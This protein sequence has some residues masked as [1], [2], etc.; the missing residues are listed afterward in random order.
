MHDV[1]IKNDTGDPIPVTNVGGSSGD[2][3][4]LDGVTASIK[5]TVKNFA[6]DKALAVSLTDSTG[7]QLGTGNGTSAAAQRVT[8]SSDST[9]ILAAITNVVQLNGQAIAMGTGVRSAGTQR[10]TI[11]TDDSVPVTNASLSV[12]GNGASAT[13]Q[14]VTLAN[15][16]TGVLATVSTVSTVTSL[17]QMNGQAITM[18]TGVRAAGTQRVTIATDDLVPVNYT[19][20]AG[21]AVSTAATGVQKV[22]VVGNAGA[23]FDGATGSAVPANAL[24]N[25]L[26]ATTANPTNAASGNTVA[27]M[28]DKAGRTVVTVGNVRELIGVQQTSVAAN[29]ETTILTSGGAGVFND[30]SQLIITTAGAAAQTITIKDATGGTTRLVLN[31]PNAAVAPGAPLVINFNPPL[32]QAAAAANWTVTQSLTTATNYTVVFVKNL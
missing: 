7:T 29:T 19:Q 5:A 27:Q 22:G 11:A 28:A 32:P 9:G 13:A 25:G 20:V 23:I 17:T 16:S 26:R 4:I 10:V 8:L 21:S 18:G 12:V 2:G 14:R 1:K 15:D 6:G 24:L 3:A 31:Y 30:I